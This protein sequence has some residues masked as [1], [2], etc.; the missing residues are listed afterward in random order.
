MT[1]YAIDDHESAGLSATVLVAIISGVVTV[2]AA[3]FGG[4]WKWMSDRGK[5]RSDAHTS[6]VAGFVSLLTS[7]QSERDRLLER[8]ARLETNDRKQSRR[9]VKL[10]RALARAGVEVPGDE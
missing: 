8:I 4:M 6:L 3:I 1:T 5:S 2:L 9:I 10:E 7:V